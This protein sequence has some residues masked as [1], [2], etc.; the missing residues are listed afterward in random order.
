MKSSQKEQ[1]RTKKE[2]KCVGLKSTRRSGASHQTV[3]CAPD[4]PVHDPGKCLIL[5]I[6]AYVDYNSPDCPRGA[7]D[8]PVCRPPTASCT[9]VEGQ[10]SSGAAD[11]PVPPRSRK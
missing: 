7:P 3:Q 8:S 2:K 6:L 4:S 5:E 11:S 10:G 1:K 9:L